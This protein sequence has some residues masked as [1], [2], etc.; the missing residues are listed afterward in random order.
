M[1]Y[2]EKYG[3]QGVIV[4]PVSSGSLK[5]VGSR[6]CGT[7]GYAGLFAEGS[8]VFSQLGYPLKM[9]F[10]A[11]QAVG[12]ALKDRGLQTLGIVVAFQHS[13]LCETVAIFGSFALFISSEK[14]GIKECEKVQKWVFC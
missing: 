9:F 12:L 14:E 2:H 3:L 1:S 5:C 10:E 4:L 13:G 7:D 6:A 8:R 11:L